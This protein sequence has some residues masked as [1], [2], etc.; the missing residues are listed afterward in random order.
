MRTNEFSYVFLQRYTHLMQ[1]N[2][3]HGSF[4]LQSKVFRAKE[5]IEQEVQQHHSQ[6][7]DSW[8]ITL[9]TLR[10]PFTE[11]LR[12]SRSSCLRCPRVFPDALPSHT[13]YWH[14]YYVTSASM[15]LIPR[16][17]SDTGLFMKL[18]CKLAFSRNIQ[19]TS[20]SDT[21]ATSFSACPSRL[22]HKLSGR[23]FCHGCC[24]DPFNE[25]IQ[26]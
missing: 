10:C 6:Q 4:Y 11:R 25:S 23:Q 2:E 21:S 24:T 3:K 7:H 1:Q 16:I 19:Y 20:M 13:W 15:V 26:F 17:V 18:M 22:L 12:V 8:L 14:Q 5:R 9:H